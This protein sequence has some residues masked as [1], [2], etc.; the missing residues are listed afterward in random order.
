MQGG[1]SREI[2]PC[3]GSYPL[4]AAQGGNMT[5]KWIPVTE[6]PPKI[7][8]HGCS[9]YILLSY[10]GFDLPDIGE[11]RVDREGGA[12]YPADDARSCTSY[13]FIVNAWAPMTIK[14]YRDENPK[15]AK[16]EVCD[17]LLE[18][19]RRTR[20]GEDVTALRY[21]KEEYSETVHVD[22]ESGKDGRII[23]VAHDS[24]WAMIKDIVK[25]IDIG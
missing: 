22:F 17:L 7:N 14:P 16:Q 3:G 5:V 9:E 8:K 23:N 21:V 18:A 6:R 10:E 20:A 25:H 4:A 19:I 12:F 13:G 1:E 11:Y 2:S 15:G 24:E